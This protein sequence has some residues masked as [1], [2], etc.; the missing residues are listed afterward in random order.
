VGLEYEIYQKEWGIC[1]G[2]RRKND[3]ELQEF[4]TR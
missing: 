4:A 2:D 1:G 3:M